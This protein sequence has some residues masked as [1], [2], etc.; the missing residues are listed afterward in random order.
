MCRECYPQEPCNRRKFLMP[1][2]HGS[3]KPAE[4][5]TDQ[6]DYKRFW[7]VINVGGGFDVVKPPEDPAPD[8][9]KDKRDDE[10]GTDALGS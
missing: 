10:E 6:I 4:V 3:A 5:R 1:E 8:N 9:G 7:Y 2:K